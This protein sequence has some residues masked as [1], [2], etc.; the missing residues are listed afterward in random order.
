MWARIVFLFVSGMLSGVAAYYGQPLVHCNTDAITILITVMTVF[1]GFLVAIIAILGDPSMLP[2]G[3]WRAAE[4]S[5]PAVYNKVVTYAWLFRLYL[6]AIAFLFAGALID[7][8][9]NAVV[10]AIWKIW[11]ERSYLF[12]GVF[13]FLCTVT[14][15]GTLGRLQMARVEAEIDRRRKVDGIKDQSA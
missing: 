2:D 6:V 3:S 7:K 4:M 13:S 10:P 14:L 12:F 11:I 5:H 15:P 1:A 9:Q 8:A